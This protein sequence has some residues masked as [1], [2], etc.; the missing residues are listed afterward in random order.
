MLNFNGI[1]EPIELYLFSD[2]LN[3]F[4]TALPASEVFKGCLTSLIPSAVKAA[5]ATATAYSRKALMNM[6]M[7]KNLSEDVFDS[8]QEILQ[9][10]EYVHEASDRDKDAEK[11]LKGLDGLIAKEVLAG[12][13]CYNAYVHADTF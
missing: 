5:T 10:L 11:A 13:L 1:A 9:L 6:L 7:H 12:F 4:Y 3:G 2:F 8:P